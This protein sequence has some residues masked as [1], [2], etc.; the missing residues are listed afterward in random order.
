[1]AKYLFG[2]LACAI[3]GT[4]SLNMFEG[5]PYWRSKAKQTPHLP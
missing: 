1:M 4:A 5:D 2:A 3:A